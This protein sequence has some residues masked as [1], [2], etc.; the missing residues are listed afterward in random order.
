MHSFERNRE[1]KIIMNFL[2]DSGA[3]KQGLL[4]AAIPKKSGGKGALSF[5]IILIL[6]VLVEGN[7]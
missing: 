5:L 7:E 1:D 6:F 3:M 2:A 4:T